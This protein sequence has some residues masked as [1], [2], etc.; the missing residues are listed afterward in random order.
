METTER[1]RL[2][3]AEIESLYP[4]HW[5]LIDEPEVEAGS[6]VVSGIVVFAHPDRKEIYRRASELKLTNVAV[7]CTKKDPPGTKYVL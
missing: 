6:V 3:I 5:I 4:D 7:R 1:K 2:P